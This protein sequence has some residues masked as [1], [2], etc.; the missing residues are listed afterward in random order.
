MLVLVAAHALCLSDARRAAYQS[1]FGRSVSHFVLSL[2]CARKAYFFRYDPP[3]C[4]K[5]CI[6]RSQ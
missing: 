6:Y 4:L 2:L 5:C 3:L 1:A